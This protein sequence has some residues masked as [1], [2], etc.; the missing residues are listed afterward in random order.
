MNLTTKPKEN[1]LFK[2]KIEEIIKGC[3]ICQKYQET[4]KN[5]KLTCKRHAILRSVA[6]QQQEDRNLT[7][8]ERDILT[9]YEH[10]IHIDDNTETVLIKSKKEIV[11]PHDDGSY[12]LTPKDTDKEIKEFRF[13]YF[14][15]VY[16]IFKDLHHLSIF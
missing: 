14:Q 7:L 15:E 16:E 4:F 2:Q 9:Q 8:H 1:Y 5:D 3:E 13:R 12:P 11:L 10:N 6:D